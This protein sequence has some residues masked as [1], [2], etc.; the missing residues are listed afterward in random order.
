MISPN[1]VSLIQEANQ[2]FAQMEKKW[3]DLEKRYNTMLSQDASRFRNWIPKAGYSGNFP[4]PEP[5][6]ATGTELVQPELVLKALAAYQSHLE[7]EIK[8]SV[9]IRAMADDIKA[10]RSEFGTA[11]RGVIKKIDELKIQTSTKAQQD[12]TDIYSALGE[13]VSS[14]RN[15]PLNSFTYMLIAFVFSLLTL[16]LLVRFFPDPIASQIF[17]S[18][19]LLQIFTVFV[20]VSSIV[21]LAIS[22]VLE[23]RELSTLI[24]AI[25]GY[26]LGQLGRAGTSAQPAA[27]PPA[28]A[29]PPRPGG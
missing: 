4:P 22:K 12:Q 2:H 28:P 11:F 24:A 25:S 19:Y 29:P 8:K 18:G 1:L 16:H 23:G 3:Q 21:I 15:L 9:D 26:V 13:I 27:P 14:A 20:L 10:F 5:Q 6:R 7:N 17:S